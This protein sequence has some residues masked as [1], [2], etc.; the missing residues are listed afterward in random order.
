MNPRLTVV[1]GFVA[2]LLLCAAT[3]GGSV[4]T[5]GVYD[6]NEVAP[7]T[8]DFVATGSSF[9]VVEFTEAV[10]EAFE[11]DRG[12][13]LF[14][15]LADELVYGVN[16]SKRLG[17]HAVDYGIAI[18]SSP[19]TPISGGAA[20]GLQ[21]GVDHGSIAFSPIIGGEPDEQVIKIALTALSA[22][23]ADYGNV[24]FSGHLS[25]GETLSASRAIS[26]EWGNGDT[27][28]GLSAPTGD[29]FTGFTLEFDGSITPFQRL[30]YD[31]VGF[32]TAIVPEPTSA[33]LLA[34]TALICLRRRARS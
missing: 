3:Y 6:E 25:S 33:M 14:D 23:D 26:E 17:Y 20:Y 19:P 32:I 8:V 12:G 11:H 10:A 16:R 22:T 13:V 34:S 5:V 18:S 31:D 15:G 9:D 30:W 29:Y 27:F 28:F 7:N 1:S 24:T 21:G 4:L 2:T